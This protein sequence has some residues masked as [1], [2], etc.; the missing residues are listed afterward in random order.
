MVPNS[1]P[2]LGRLVGWR[3]LVWALGV[4]LALPCVLSAQDAAPRV[5]ID[6]AASAVRFSIYGGDATVGPV[7][8][9]GWAG[10]VSA[11]STSGL[12]GE[13]FLSLLPA[14]DDPY[15]P[16][17]RLTTFGGWLTLGLN[18][19]PHEG[20]DIFGGAGMAY[21][22]VRGW[23]DFSDCTLDVG[24]FAEGGPNFENGG[25]VVTVAGGGVLYSFRPLAVRGDVRVIPSNSHARQRT[26]QLG[27]GVA[28]LLR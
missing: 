25:S 26:V 14:S 18:R 21:L 22:A 5:A 7:A 12:G 20:F 1:L 2:G 13:L 27:L 15:D 4:V 17:P 11:R 28:V 10:S 23:P 3:A 16:S 8:N 19:T 9:I 24:C 6:V